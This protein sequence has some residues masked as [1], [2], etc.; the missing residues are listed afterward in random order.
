MINKVYFGDNLPILREKVKDNSIDLIYIDPPFNT[1]KSRILTRI[2]AIQSNDGDRKGYV[3]KSY[4]TIKLDTQ[5]FDDNYGDVYETFLEMRLL[6][7]RRVLAEHGMLYFHIDYREV[8]YCRLLLDRIFG[9]VCY[10]NE[11]IWAY[12]YGGRPKTRWPAKHDNILVYAKNPRKNNFKSEILQEIKFEAPEGAGK[13]EIPPTDVWWHTI[14]PT[15]GNERT[16]YPTQKPL[17]ILNRIIN[18]SSNADDL[19]LDFFAGSGTTGES[20]LALGRR[21][22]L[23]DNNSQAKE[24]MQKRFDPYQDEVEFI[25]YNAEGTVISDDG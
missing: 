8:H 1:R 16:G 13:V 14:V 19:V 5:S 3:G 23:I 12:D 22:I 24:V 9:P 21:F 11:I 18:V 7:A 25:D 4:K 20:C 17:G 10:L 6:E 2:R 15:N